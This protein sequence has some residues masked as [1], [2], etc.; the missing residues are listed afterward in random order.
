MSHAMLTDYPS[1]NRKLL[2]GVAFGSKQPPSQM[3]PLHSEPMYNI[4]KSMKPPSAIA[5]KETVLMPDVNTQM[6]FG[7]MESD[8]VDNDSD[9]D[10]QGAKKVNP[11]I[12]QAFSN[13]V[14]KTLKTKF[15]PQLKRKTED[16]DVSEKQS[17]PKKANK[18]KFY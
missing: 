2:P 4:N 6:G 11:S 12:L 16:T 18:L 14:F 5:I 3:V 7:L 1:S 8:E 10:V 15:T 17:K 13:P 9:I